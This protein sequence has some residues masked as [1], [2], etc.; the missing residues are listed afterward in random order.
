MPFTGPHTVRSSPAYFP[1]SD[2]STKF[3]G[4]TVGDGVNASA[5]VDVRVHSGEEVGI[6]VGVT[7]KIVAVSVHEVVGLLAA[8]VERCSPSEVCIV[9]AVC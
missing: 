6:S 4:V 2:Q 5:G 1:A 3:E 7:G 8:G 9:T